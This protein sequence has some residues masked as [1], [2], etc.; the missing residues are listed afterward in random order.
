MYDDHS[1]AIM[2]Q[3]AFVKTLIVSIYFQHGS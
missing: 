2:A 3:D 1:V